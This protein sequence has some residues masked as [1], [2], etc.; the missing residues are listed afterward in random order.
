MLLG[1][2]TVM[3]TSE[4]ETLLSIPRK[5][6]LRRSKFMSHGQPPLPAGVSLSGIL[7]QILEGFC[8]SMCFFLQER[9][10]IYN[11]CKTIGPRLNTD[12]VPPRKMGWDPQLGLS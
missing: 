3:T 9:H 11:A 4:G 1:T 5:M 10:F 12:S 2:Q 6:A 8:V 7:L